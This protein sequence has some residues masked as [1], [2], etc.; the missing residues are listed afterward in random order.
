MTTYIVY[1]SLTEKSSIFSLFFFPA[2]PM[3][4]RLEK[5]CNAAFPAPAGIA[6]RRGSA[7]LRPRRE[8]SAQIPVGRRACASGTRRRRARSGSG[9]GRS[10]APPECT[11]PEECVLPVGKFPLPPLFPLEQEI[12]QMQKPQVIHLV[13]S[14]GRKRT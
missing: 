9:P 14:N 11:V 4:N 7:P 2:L 8:A 13:R 5:P 10:P 3:V 12:T 6:V 1:H